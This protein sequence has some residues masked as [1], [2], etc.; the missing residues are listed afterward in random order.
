MNSP[1]HNPPVQGSFDFDAAAVAQQILARTAPDGS[2]APVPPQGVHQDRYSDAPF[3]VTPHGLVLDSLSDRG[4]AEAFAYLY[5]REY[6]HVNGLGWYKW[7][8]YRW[9]LDEHDR[10]VWAAGDM[11]KKLARIDDQNDFTPSEMKRAR[12]RALSTAGI[13]SMLAQAQA[14]DGLLLGAALLDADP[15]ALCTPGG[16]VDLRTGVT[17][18]PDPAKHLHSRAT[19][20]APRQMPIPRWDRFLRDTFGEDAEGLQ[21]IKFLHLLLGYSI[22]GD[23]GAQVLI[24]LHGLG[25][26]GKSVLLDTLVK[27]LGEYADAAPPGFLMAKPFD[28]HPTDLAELHGRR[29]IVCSEL[30][31]GDRFD[32]ARVKLLTGG[33]R[34]KARRMRQDFFSFTPTHKLWLLGNHKPEVGTGGFAFWRRMRLVPFEKVVPDHQ[35][36]DNLADVLVNEEGPG[37]LA[38]LI[39]G[40][41]R[42]LGGERD[43]SGPERVRLA[44]DAYADTEDHLGRFLKEACK[45]EPGLR[46]EQKTLYLAYQAWCDGEPEVARPV[47]SRTFASRVREALGMRSPSEMATSN[48]RKYYPGIGLLAEVDGAEETA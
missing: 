37:I 26:N 33:D 48:S 38:W 35:K 11:A 45:I 17:L 36:I 34:I 15:Y 32:E 41:R 2:N 18:T 8:T 42:Y 23:V 25:K 29:V 13:K 9:V 28:G 30:K 16:I 19:S 24:F 14:A 46:A 5:A 22:T 12:G 10:V 31:A 3:R 6:R 47:S 7:D 39:D 4:L 21:M 44:T 43:L 20:V 40:A 1:I 27:L